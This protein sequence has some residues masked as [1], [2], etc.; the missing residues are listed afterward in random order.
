MKAARK[1]L[2]RES[3]RIV[4]AQQSCFISIVC[5]F[6]LGSSSSCGPS[7]LCDLVHS[8]ATDPVLASQIVEVRS[9]SPCDLALQRILLHLRCYLGVAKSLRS[10]HSHPGSS[11]AREG[12]YKTHKKPQKLLQC[13]IHLRSH[14]IVKIHC[15][16]FTS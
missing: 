14:F 11:F 12:K 8:R 7:D 3:V 6:L 5:A 1:R 13:R 9:C 16:A 10:S 4:Q 15:R 2:R